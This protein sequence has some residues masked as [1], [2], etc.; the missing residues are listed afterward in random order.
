MRHFSSVVLVDPRGHL[1]LQERDE[2]AGID[3]ERWGF[4]GGHLER[5]ES[6]E[7]AARRELAEETGVHLP[8]ALVEIGT[9]WITHRDPAA[10]AEPDEV[11][12][13]AAAVDLADGDVACH[14]GRR[15][16]FVDPAVARD[17]PLTVA[18]AVILPDFLDSRLYGSMRS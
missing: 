7:A 12:L 13:Y 9:W 4:P 18:A 10:D 1:L 17:L 3:P 5:D 2:H 14:E 6:P 11:H 15:M 8:G 16:V